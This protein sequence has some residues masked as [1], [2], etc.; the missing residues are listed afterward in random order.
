MAFFN[1][2]APAS[3]AIAK[4]LAEAR[5][6]RESIAKQLESARADYGRCV[7][8]RRN[9]IIDATEQS[10]LTKVDAL[11]HRAGTDVEAFQDA[12]THLGK[13]IA[14]LEE[15]FAAA[16]GSEERDNRPPIWRPGQKSFEMR[17]VN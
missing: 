10:A 15:S 16:R 4:A 6:R 13:K 12:L 9:A 14:T 8:Q 7:E 2:G 11:V 5:A 17:D 3:Q 1:N